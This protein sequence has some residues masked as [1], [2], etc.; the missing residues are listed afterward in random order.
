MAKINV[1]ANRLR[2][3]F[4]YDGQTGLFTRR[5][6]VG[7]TKVGDVLHCLDKDGYIQVMIDRGKYKVHR[8]AWLYVHGSWPKAHIDHINGNPA[9]NRI[10]NLRE[11]SDAQNQQNRSTKNG[12]VGTWFDKGRGI[13]S[14]R[15]VLNRKTTHL[16]WFA[17]QELAH[18]A[19]LSAKMQ[20][21]QFSPVPRSHIYNID[22]AVNSASSC[23]VVKPRAEAM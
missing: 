3:L 23:S 19:Y 5:V 16:G 2:E 4:H 13:W 11:A 15:I 7:K 8:L 22:A 18:A 17:S 21:H 6:S 14:A 9:D 12:S 10:A 20:M 1:T